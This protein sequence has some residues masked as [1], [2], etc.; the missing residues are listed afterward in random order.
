MILL[1]IAFLLFL[2]YILKNLLKKNILISSYILERE[3]SIFFISILE[4]PLDGYFLCLRNNKK[5]FKEFT[6]SVNDVFGSTKSSKSVGAR[7]TKYLSTMPDYSKNL[8]YRIKDPLLNIDIQSVERKHRQTKETG[9]RLAII[10]CKTGQKNPLEMM[11]NEMS[12]SFNTFLTHMGIEKVE[13]DGPVEIIWESYI[14]VLFDV[15]AY[16]NSEQHRRLIGNDQVTIFFKD[17]GEPFDPSG[18]D[19]IGVVPQIFL[20]VQ[21]YQ[22]KYR[23]TSFRRKNIKKSFNPQMPSNYLFHSSRLQDF[24]LKKVYNGLMQSR[25]Y[26]PMKRLYETPRATTITEIATKF[27]K[28]KKKKSMKLNPKKRVTL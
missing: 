21:P 16:M 18:I 8:I 20:V 24:I 9:F 13:E 23:I 4:E 17:E 5:G 12:E 3:M 25:K 10:Y 27:I 28:K 19:S 14:P 22:N 26:Q 7:L 2:I 1:L 6:I 11:K 15:A